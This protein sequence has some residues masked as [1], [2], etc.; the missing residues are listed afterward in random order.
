MVAVHHLTERKRQTF[1]SLSVCLLRASF[2]SSPSTSFLILFFLSPSLPSLGPGHLFFGGGIMWS[3]GELN[4]GAE[5][6]AARWIIDGN[7]GVTRLG[8]LTSL[9]L[10]LAAG[11]TRQ[12]GGRE[13]GR[14]RGEG[15][16][17]R[18]SPLFG[19]RTLSAGD[20][21]WIMDEKTTML[22]S[23]LELN[24]SYKRWSTNRSAQIN[25]S[26]VKTPG[27]EMTCTLI[28]CMFNSVQFHSINSIREPT[29]SPF[30]IDT[31]VQV[32]LTSFFNIC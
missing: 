12:N 24:G 22:K 3:S 7:L 30:T 1:E 6:A 5:A 26:W 23:V 10:H 27:G 32:A 14:E 21:K 9:L 20:S 11:L 16:R 15:E 4:T 28:V 8:L 2:S 31:F 17:E 18:R 13:R 19:W 29:A 25:K